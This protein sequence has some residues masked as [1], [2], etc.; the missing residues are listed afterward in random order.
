MFTIKSP[1][2]NM[3]LV[4]VA[5]DHMLYALS[6]S[7]ED[8]AY[9][10]DY[11]VRFETEGNLESGYLETLCEQIKALDCPVC[12]DMRHISSYASRGFQFVHRNNL[13]VIFANVSPGAESVRERLRQDVPELVTYEHC[14]EVLCAKLPQVEALANRRGFREGLER[15]Y[16][17]KLCAL[18]DAVAVRDADPLGTPLDS[19]GVYVNHYIALK[20]LFLEMDNAMFV[21]YKMAE[22]VRMECPSLEKKVLVCCSKTGAAFTSLLS[23]LLGLK[24][25]YCVSI[26]PKFALDMENLKREIQEGQE[27]I[28][29][30][31]FLCM[32]TE[33]KILHALISM[34]GGRLVYGIGVAS[35]L[36][37]SAP[38]FQDSIF[39]RLHTLM[40]IRK[41]V[42]DYRVRPIVPE[43]IEG[44]TNGD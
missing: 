43:G 27:Y 8:T 37:I 22:K 36:N 23:M 31:D 10:R 42:P 44:S 20:N 33:V 6:Q 12:L 26:G 21:V 39:S 17:G 15:I 14:S 2:E 35:Y 30:F 18:L 25:V 11:S 24:A 1:A 19:S 7:L 13:P 32:G 28:Y 9:E 38:E 3:Y 29:V 34:L 41:A 5:F 16:E 40:D 4:P